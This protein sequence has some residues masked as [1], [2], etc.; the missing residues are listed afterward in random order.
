[1]TFWLWCFGVHL[2]SLCFNLLVVLRL[3]VISFYDD[4]L[5]CPPRGQFFYIF[6][7]QNEKEI[8]YRTKFAKSVLFNQCL[9]V[10]ICTAPIRT[11]LLGGEVFIDIY[12]QKWYHEKLIHACFITNSH[13]TKFESQWGILKCYPKIYIHI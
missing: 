6:R 13:W 8:I 11:I 1:M 10:I 3:I 7:P 2:I 5:F 4:F 12:K 9:T